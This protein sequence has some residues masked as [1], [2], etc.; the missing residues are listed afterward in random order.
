MFGF[1][2]FQLNCNLLSGSDISS[3]V[4][5]PE[6]AAPDLPAQPVPVANPQLHEGSSVRPRPGSAALPALPAR[7]PLPHSPA[8]PDA[9]AALV[10]PLDTSET[11]STV[12]A[13]PG[14][15]GRGFRARPSP[16]PLRLPAAIL[17]DL[18]SLATGAGRAGCGD[19]RDASRG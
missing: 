16:Q 19:E 17:R 2:T 6:G 3:Q 14:K 15:D 18:T 1:D 8:V 12:A 7:A 5:V 9:I 10:Q 13:A 4:D 11:G